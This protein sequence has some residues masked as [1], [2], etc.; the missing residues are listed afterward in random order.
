LPR[1]AYIC[2][3]KESG[4]A[5]LLNRLHGF[6]SFGVYIADDNPGAVSREE[7]SRGATDTRAAT[8]NECYFIR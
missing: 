8:G 4:T 7:K 1:V 5:L 6:A 2:F 3:D